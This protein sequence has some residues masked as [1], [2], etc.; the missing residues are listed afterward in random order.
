MVLL[1]CAEEL[2]E[3]GFKQG[4]RLAVRSEVGEVM[5][6]VQPDDRV[7]R[8]TVYVPTGLSETSVL[9]SVSVVVVQAM[10]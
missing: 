4:G 8:G 9:G 5:L 7:P 1:A 2:E 3:L 10:E 6:P